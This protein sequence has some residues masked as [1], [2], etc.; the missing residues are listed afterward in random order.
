LRPIL[1]DA[2]QNQIKIISNMGA[3]NPKSA[4]RHIHKLADELGLAPFKIAVLTGD[5]IAE[6]LDR[7]EIMDAKTMEGTSLAGRSLCSANAYLGGDAVARALATDADIVLAGR[8]TDSALVLGPLIHEFGWQAEEYDKL[9]AGTICGHLLECGAQIT[10]AYFADPD[11]KDVPN[12]AEVGFPLAEVGEEGTFIITKPEGT[13]GCVTKATV[14]EQLLYEMHDPSRYLVPDVSADVTSMELAE[15]GPNRIHVSGIKGHTPP[16]SLKVTVCVDGGYM[17]EAEMSYAGLNA[18]K[19]ARL[20]GEVV[21]SRMRASGY[22][23]D[24]R[25][26]ILGAYSVLDGGKTEFLDEKK[27]PFNSDYR[28]RLALISEDRQTA[29]LLCDE[30][31]HLY[32]SGPAGGGGYRA[33]VSEQMASASILVDKAL[34]APHIHAEVIEHD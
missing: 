30:L 18:F 23:G 25:M 17:A 20:A 10:G 4:A 24:I 8:T 7:Q 6:Y 12:L 27:L 34:V 9:A 26:D 32:C 15:H 29:Q 1:R 31:Q 13:G 21:Q 33:H 28:V 2:Q 22:N 16:D 11:F 3:A 5:D 19:R 14:T